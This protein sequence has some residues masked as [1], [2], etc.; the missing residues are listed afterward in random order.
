MSKLIS[1]VE[2]GDIC[3]EDFL[4][5]L[6]KSDLK[7]ITLVETL[8]ERWA[9]S[10]N[11]GKESSGRITVDLLNHILTLVTSKTVEF[12]TKLQPLLSPLQNAVK[13][14]S[15]LP[16]ISMLGSASALISAKLGSVDKSETD[17]VFFGKFISCYVQT[18]T[19]CAAKSRS[20]KSFDPAKVSDVARYLIVALRL[21]A[22]AFASVA[23][24]PEKF[25]LLLT[26]VL[27]VSWVFLSRVIETCR[28][29]DLISALRSALIAVQ[30]SYL[31]LSCARA[32]ET[33]RSVDNNDIRPVESVYLL[34]TAD[35][36]RSI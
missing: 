31:F 15:L 18:V 1:T 22:L 11:A 10:D 20:D 4:P 36:C 27:D 32:I 5:S 26:Y 34:L 17:S 2:S 9:S 33:V 19:Q 14:A 16:V 29:D 13:I 25:V 7:L 30:R 35:I 24:E 23:M 6:Q 21:E 28:A 3:L 12:S 8:R